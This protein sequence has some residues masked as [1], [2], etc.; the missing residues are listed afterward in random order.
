MP[1]FTYM[2]ITQNSDNCFLNRKRFL[3]TIIKHTAIDMIRKKNRETNISLEELEEWQLPADEGGMAA[4]SEENRIVTAIKHMPEL[5]RDVFLLKYSSGYENREI[6]DILEIS[7]A[8]VRKRISRG[9]KKLEVLLNG[10]NM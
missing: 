9:K 7:E 5:Y 4:Q 2:V 1:P 8:S 3:L 10:E 6:A